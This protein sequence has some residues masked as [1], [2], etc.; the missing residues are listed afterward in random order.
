M[1]KAHPNVHVNSY[2][3]MYENQTH[4]IRWN[5]TNI[6]QS[7]LQI[8]ILTGN[9]HWFKSVYWRTLMWAEDP[10]LR[11]SALFHPASSQSSWVGKMSVW[12]SISHDEMLS[13]RQLYGVPSLEGSAFPGSSPLAL[14]PRKR[15]VHGQWGAGGARHLY[16]CS[17]SL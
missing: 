14:P 15:V 7:E 1:W 10:V 3:G 16:P 5:A 17:L 8:V 2:L 9:R 12:R 11:T 13:R 4:E 6:Y